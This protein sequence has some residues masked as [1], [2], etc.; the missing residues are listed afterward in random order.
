MPAAALLALLP[1]LIQMVSGASQSAKASRYANTQ[2]PY[3]PVPQGLLDA[4]D[5]NKNMALQTGYPR[6]DLLESKIDESIAGNIG[7]AR[8]AVKS[9][10]EL[11]SL[12]NRM[13]EN[14][15]ENL[16]DLSV[17]GEQLGQ[18]NKQ[19]YASIL[20]DLAASQEKGYM[21]NE[22]DPYLQAMNASRSLRGAGLQNIYSGVSSAVGSGINYMD[23]NSVKKAQ[24]ANASSSDLDSLMGKLQP[25]NP[26]PSYK[27]TA[28]NYFDNPIFQ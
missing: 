20:M 11:S 3:M 8:D 16:K 24:E 13:Y 14:K 10:W 27:I 18:V 25:S 12:S 26:V 2:R 17:K 19:N 9:P 5:I 28:P 7:S 21:M 1:S 4:V 15:T 23:V 6:A 22:Y